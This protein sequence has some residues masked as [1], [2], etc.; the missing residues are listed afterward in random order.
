MSPYNTS[1]IQLD[2]VSRFDAPNA[3]KREAAGAAIRQ[4]SARIDMLAI[5]IALTLAVLIR[6][7]ILPVIGW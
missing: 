7:N 1:N 5:G 6:F 2:Q 3:L 4:R